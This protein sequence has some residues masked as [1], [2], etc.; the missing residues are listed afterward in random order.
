VAGTQINGQNLATASTNLRAE[1]VTIHTLLEDL[2][3]LNAATMAR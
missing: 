2:K 3:D 1:H